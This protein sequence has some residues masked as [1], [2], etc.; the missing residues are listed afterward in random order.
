[1]SK[2]KGTS[3]KVPVNVRDF[4]ENLSST[5]RSKTNG[6]SIDKKRLTQY[7]TWDL[8]VQYFEGNRERYLELIKL[9]YKENV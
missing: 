7:K 9:E 1:M 6:S 8:I 5:R 4:N 2:E 3:T